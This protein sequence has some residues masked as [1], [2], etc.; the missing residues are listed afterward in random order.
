MELPPLRGE[1]DRINTFFAISVIYLE[2]I[3]CG[4]GSLFEHTAQMIRILLTQSVCCPTG[5]SLSGDQDG[6][7]APSLYASLWFR[8]HWLLLSDLVR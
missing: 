1:P 2:F 7:S 4:A 8:R 5:K 3:R 6:T